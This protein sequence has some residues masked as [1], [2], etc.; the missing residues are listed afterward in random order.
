M[1]G[2]RCKRYKLIIFKNFDN[3]SSVYKTNASQEVNL[4]LVN[5]ST[6]LF[7]HLIVYKVILQ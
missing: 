7:Q 5:I 1:F 2:L 3:F 6:L 4:I